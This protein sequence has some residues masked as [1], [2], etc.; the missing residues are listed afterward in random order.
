MQHDADL[1]AQPGR[2]DLRQIHP[3]HEN[4]PPFRDIQPLNQLR[5]GALPGTGPSNDPDDLPWRNRER[6][7]PQDF[8]TIWAIAKRHLIKHHLTGHLG[9][10]RPV[11]I[12]GGFRLRIEHI[13]QS[14]HRHADLLKLL[15]EIDHPQQRP[16]DLCRQ[17]IEGDQLADT[18][19]P[20]DDPIGPHPQYGHRRHLLNQC[21]GLTGHDHHAGG[22]ETRLHITGQ[23]LF[24]L[25][26]ERGLHGHG[27]HGLNPADRL[28]KEGLV[29]CPPRELFVQPRADHGCDG[30]REEGITRQRRHNHQRQHRAVEPHDDEK[31][32]GKQ[33]IEHDRDRM[34]R[35]KL[36]DMLQLT[37]PGDR[38]PHP[39][40]FKIGQRERQNMAK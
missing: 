6:D 13:A 15:P 8:R 3:V 28:N 32:H 11:R 19:T 40:R 25:T 7:L 35:Q 18:Q 5:D 30:D 38:I 17:H 29:L 23:L 36:P 27:L 4:A 22:A 16:R 14:L 34:A 1:P 2:V 39:P 21:R 37:H 9:K 12:V 20:F 33:H 10:R 31:D 26:Q 24:P